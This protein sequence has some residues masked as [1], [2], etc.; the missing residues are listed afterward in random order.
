MF[1]SVVI[2]CFN[3]KENLN[4]GV[5]KEVAGFLT[6]QP[7]EWEIVVSDD[8]STD[9]SRELVRREIENNPKIRLLENPHGGKALAVRAGILS[10]NGKYSLA[11]DMDQSTPVSELTKLLPY[12][13][14][15]YDI[16]FGSRG[17]ERKDFPLYR[18]LGSII[19]KSIR[20]SL[21]LHKVDDTQCG[22]KLFD[23]EKIKKVFPKMEIFKTDKKVKGWRVGAWDIELL[24]VALKM[25][26]KIK[27]VPVVWKQEDITKGKKQNYFKESKEMLLEVLRVKIND[28]KGV[29]G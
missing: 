4:R 5:L 7:F 14:E 18:K 28:L 19:F 23:T 3:E 13:K 25:G 26:L 8:Q 6:S 27:E 2:P 17:L 20:Q 12:L 9:E 10:A 11:T 21:L 1:L 22:F 29:Y 16:V 15:N 24:F